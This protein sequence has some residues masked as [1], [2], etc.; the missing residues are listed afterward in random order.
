VRV[1]KSNESPRSDEIFIWKAPASY[2][3]EKDP[4]V[5]KAREGHRLMMSPL[6]IF[7]APKFLFDSVSEFG[8]IQE[9]PAEGE[10]VAL[11]LT[12]D[13]L[14]WIRNISIGDQDDLLEAIDRFGLFSTTGVFQH[15]F[16]FN[17][18]KI[19]SAIKTAL[20][21]LDTLSEDPREALKHCRE[22]EISGTYRLIEPKACRFGD[23]CKASHHYQLEDP[24]RTAF[25]YLMA[26]V[27]SGL[28]A[29]SVT[30]GICLDEAF[31]FKRDF[32]EFLDATAAFWELI[33]REV[34]KRKFPIICPI[35][36]DLVH[37][38]RVS[39]M[40]CNKARCKKAAQRLREKEEQ[41]I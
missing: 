36:G 37:R 40:Y 10:E 25:A 3:I 33:A 11:V 27:N 15:C 21:L 39:R 4:L 34:V 24:V 5:L 8:C 12:G 35:C 31:R 18:W 23:E 22:G 41:F 14:D 19:I 1:L 17:E 9:G 28:Y 32:P 20:W 13:D 6:S 29:H 2:R 7:D 30:S 16:V 38:Q 26:L